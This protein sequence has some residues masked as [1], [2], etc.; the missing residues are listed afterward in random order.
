WRLQLAI[1]DLAGGA[2]P[3][4]ARTAALKLSRKRHQPSEGIRLLTALSPIF[5]TRE[6]ITS[7]EMIDLLNTDPTGEWYEFRGR[8]P[9]TQRQ[10]AALLADYDIAPVVL[11][12]TKRATVSR[13]GYRK[14][15]FIE[16]FLRYLPNDP[17]IRTL[18]SKKE[19]K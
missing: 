4:A 17:N 13:H 11:H 8:G 3:K 16:T 19:K 2:F 18:S 14:S 10:V 12:P 7:K 1:A 9:I 6:E 15:Q 5:A